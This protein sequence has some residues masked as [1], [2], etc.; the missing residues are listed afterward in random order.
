M[1]SEVRQVLEFA[2]RLLAV[3]D[4]GRKTATYKYAVLLALMDLCLITRDESG[5]APSMVT[6]E[7]LAERVVELYWPHARR[8]SSEEEGGR[9]LEQNTGKRQAEIITLICR[10]RQSCAPDPTAA[11]S[12]ARAAARPEFERLVKDVEWKLV[13]MPLPKLQRLLGGDR[14]PFLYRIAWDDEVKRAEFNDAGRFDNRIHLLPGTGEWLA[15]LGGLL[16]PIIERRWAA[17]VGRLNADLVADVQLEEFLFGIDR[18]S[19]EPVK[20]PLLELQEH[21]CFFC[22]ERVERAGQVDHF[23][24]WSRHPTNALDNLVVAHDGC[25]LSKSDHL[26]AVRHLE[27]WSRHRRDRKGELARIAT[28]H[29]WEG[30]SERTLGIVRGIY[31]RLPAAPKLW[32]EGRVFESGSVEGIRRALEVG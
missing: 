27:R 29:A 3:L 20:K 18:S 21:R 19:L 16:R 4:E 12:R 22:T 11:L 2:Q 23:I 24:A 8:F 7:Q 28:E 1:N 17:M 9:V 31:L 25:N 6:T 13:E 14:E 10:F 32:V 5:A 30:P 15:E 26:V